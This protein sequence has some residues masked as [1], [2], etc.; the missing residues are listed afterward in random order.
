MQSTRAWWWRWGPALLI[1]AVIFAASGTPGSDL[2]EFGTLDLAFKKGGHLLGY[3]L[4]GAAYLHGLAGGLWGNRRVRLLAILLAGL[5][6]MT[7]EFHQSFIAGRTASPVDVGI[8]TVGAS[9][10]AF[11]SHWLKSRTAPK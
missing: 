7:D 10:G 2:P 9:V 3:A 6:S 8:D 1:M 5:Y 4:L 11:L